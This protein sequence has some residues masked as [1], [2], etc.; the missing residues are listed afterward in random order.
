MLVVIEKWKRRLVQ[1]V[2]AVI[3]FGVPVARLR[4]SIRL[5]RMSVD[6]QTS[7]SAVLDRPTPSTYKLMKVYL[8]LFWR[9]KRLLLLH[10]CD[11]VNRL[12]L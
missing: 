12:I 2:L 1:R 8:E 5:L 4:N 3:E 9:R 11:V 6:G 7:D 10:C